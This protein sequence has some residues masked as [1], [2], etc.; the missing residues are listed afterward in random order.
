MKSFCFKEKII[1]SQ[2]FSFQKK[3]LSIY[4][5]MTLSL[6]LKNRGEK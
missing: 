3:D 6:K 1:K 5:L 2:L 4:E